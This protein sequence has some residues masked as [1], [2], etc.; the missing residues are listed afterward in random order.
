MEKEGSFCTHKW[1]NLH[2][3]VIA[4]NL[5][6]SY[7]SIN[8]YKTK[9]EL[10]REIVKYLFPHFIDLLGGEDKWRIKLGKGIN[11]IE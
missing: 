3:F 10:L 7:K 5:Y 6:A 8:L 9:I 11:L 4:M 2:K 1:Q